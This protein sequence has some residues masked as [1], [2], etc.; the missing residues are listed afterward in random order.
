MRHITPILCLLGWTLSGLAAAEAELVSKSAEGTVVYILAP[1]DGATVDATFTVKFGLRGMGVAPAGI[2]L[3]NTGHHHLL[4]DHAGDVN[5]V[6]PLPTS[7]QVRH[8]G[9]GQTETQITLAPGQHTLQLLLGNYLH[10][11][12]DPPVASEII[13]ITVR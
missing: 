10:I 4:V 12:H 13:T 7:D 1:T 11:P 9:G 6:Q 3:V 8:F 2:D 5:Y